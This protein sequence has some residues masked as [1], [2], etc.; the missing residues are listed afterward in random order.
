MKNYG[1]LF[2][3]S[4]VCISS[5]LIKAMDRPN[6]A[7]ALYKGVEKGPMNSDWFY[8]GI[9]PHHHA[10]DLHQNCEWKK[11]TEAYEK[12]KN[13]FLEFYTTGG[14]Y[15]SL[16]MITQEEVVYTK[17]MARLNL[18]ACLMAQRKATEHWGSFDV[19]IGIPQ[20]KRISKA[21]VNI[22]GKLHERS[23]LVRT[24]K[25]GI[26]DI[27]HFLEAANVLKKRTCCNV[28]LSVR[29]FLKG[30]LAGAAEAYGFGLVGEK[31]EQPKTDYTTHIIGLLGHLELDPAHT[32]PERVMLTAPERAIFSVN[33]QINPILAQGK[34]LAAVFSGENRQATLIGGKQLPRN[35]KVHGRHLDLEPFNELL[36]NYPE[37][38]LMDCGDKVKNRI[39]IYEDL[40]NQYMVIPKEQQPFDTIVALALAMNVNKKIIAF[41]ADNGP[42]NVFARALNKEAQRR[43]AFV[44]PNGGKETGEYDMRMEGEGSVYTQ[45]ISNCL[46][47]KCETPADQTAVIEKAYQDMTIDKD[48]VEGADRNIQ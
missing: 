16:H 15:G 26:G 14:C 19:L 5:V 10:N 4:I 37:L 45:M 20:E 8:S 46:V 17:H 30:T 11:A 38:V 31:E 7:V 42:T 21:I 13:Q 36:I 32:A 47:Y 6:L 35:P 34:T 18:A 25:V 44:I 12:T 39:V 3:M 24:D 2:L 28:I 22:P 27:V 48:I 33:E 1:Y 23:V 41:G 40:Y 43:M 29:D 9:P